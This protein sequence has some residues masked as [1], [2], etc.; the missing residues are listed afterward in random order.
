MV[1]LIR[2]D[3]HLIRRKLSGEVYKSIKFC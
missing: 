2:I 3:I 1:Y